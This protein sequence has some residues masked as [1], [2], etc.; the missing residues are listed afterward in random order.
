MLTKA[1]ACS[2]GGPDRL[3]KRLPQVVTDSTRRGARQLVDDKYALDQVGDDSTERSIAERDG[4]DRA[5]V[6][7]LSH[8]PAHSHDAGRRLE[9]R[10]RQAE[11]SGSIGNETGDLAELNGL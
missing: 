10:D 2:G 3:A 11:R 4:D 7:T 5:P 9:D 8:G 6:V 1:Y